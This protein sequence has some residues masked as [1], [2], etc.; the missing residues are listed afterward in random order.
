MAIADI[1]IEEV[2]GDA[3]GLLR[4]TLMPRW[5][6]TTS[7]VASSGSL[8]NRS[9]VLERGHFHQAPVFWAKILGGG[10]ETKRKQ[11]VGH[12]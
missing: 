11:R 10:L 3:P 7:S 9:W 1:Q 8:H 2:P 5:A 4:L 6:L 12:P